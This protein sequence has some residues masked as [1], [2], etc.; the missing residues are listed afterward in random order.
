MAQPKHGVTSLGPTH[1]GGRNKP[2]AKIYAKTAK[3]PVWSAAQ[4]LEDGNIQE[5]L[6]SYV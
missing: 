1:V 6:P 5:K 4:T 2:Y 3:L